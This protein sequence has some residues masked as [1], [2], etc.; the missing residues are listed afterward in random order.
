LV[1]APQI[2]VRP[3]RS[4]LRIDQTAPFERLVVALESAELAN[5]PNSLGEVREQPGITE[6][7]GAV[8]RVVNC[9]E[10]VDATAPRHQFVDVFVV[11]PYVIC[12]QVDRVVL[13]PADPT[14]EVF[15][16]QQERSLSFNK[17]SGTGFPGDP[18]PDDDRLDTPVG[19]H[20]RLTGRGHSVSPG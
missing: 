15:A 17:S 13:G 2:R 20:R 9:G 1:E 8:T 18:R 3:D 14:A 6:P 11:G 12:A 16:D 5:E 4:S 7:I 10:G 19:R